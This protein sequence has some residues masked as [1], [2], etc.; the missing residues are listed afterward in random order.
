MTCS[1][2]IVHIPSTK[3]MQSFLD[4]RIKMFIIM[5][6]SNLQVATMKKNM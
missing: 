4:E 3:T 5:L 6:K 1:M 2:F